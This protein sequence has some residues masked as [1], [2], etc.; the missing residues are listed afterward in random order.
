MF[1][2]GPFA[3]RYYG[4]CIALGIIVA[5]WLTGRELERTGYDGAWALDS[6]F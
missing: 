3:L 2:V 4:L 6:L 5:T 1:E